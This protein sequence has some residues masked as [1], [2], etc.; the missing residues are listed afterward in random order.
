MVVVLLFLFGYD[1]SSLRVQY[2]GERWVPTGSGCN[3][4]LQDDDNLLG[5]LESVYLASSVVFFTPAHVA[6]FFLSVVHFLT[7]TREVNDIDTSLRL[8]GESYRKFLFALHFF[9]LLRASLE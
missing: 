8:G 9:I 4:Q 5:D 3:R 1:H 2:D 6:F 7:L